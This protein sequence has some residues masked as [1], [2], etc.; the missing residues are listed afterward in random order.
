M[1][2]LL[3]AL[4]AAPVPVATLA[5]PANNHATITLS[6]QFNSG[7]VDDPE[8]QAGITALAASVMASGGTQA[9]SAEQLLTA[10]FPMATGVSLET[11][12]ELTTFTATFHKD[13]LEAMTKILGDIVLHPRWDA[14][15]FARLR[16]AAVSDIDKRLRQNDDENLGKAALAELLYR[17]TAYARI[18]DGHVSDL[19]KLTLDEV[20][21]HAQKVFTRSRLVIGIA[22]GEPGGGVTLADAAC[23]PARPATTA[24]SKPSGAWARNSRRVFMAFPRHARE[25]A[26]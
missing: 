19:K 16:D 15:E 14:R 8:G 12:R 6:L 18:E 3:L 9:L 7:S 21:A 23:A 13:H 26:R 25:G 5:L 11:D 2:A 20:K 4:A 22:P 24:P 1:I 10:L 17:G